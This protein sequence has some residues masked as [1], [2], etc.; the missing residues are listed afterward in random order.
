[1]TFNKP[2]QWG[3]SQ[4]E[5]GPAANLQTRGAVKLYGADPAKTDKQSAPKG[6]FRG[7]RVFKPVAM[8]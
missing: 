4:R 7:A 2:K 5:L 8:K 3:K 1:M 6:F